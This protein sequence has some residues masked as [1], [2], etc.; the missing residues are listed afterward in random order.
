MLREK[1]ADMYR[2][3][4]IISL[5]GF[6]EKFVFQGVH[7]DFDYDLKGDWTEP[8]NERVSKFV[9]I[10]KKLDR[11][12]LTDGFRGCIV[13][14]LRFKVGDAVEAKVQKGWTPGVVLKTWER[15]GMQVQP[16]RIKLE[17]GVEVYGPFDNDKY[18]R[19]PELQ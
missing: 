18:V 13:P 5:K 16:Y 14:E 1:N 15:K 19:R 10:G 8:E 12:M 17:T 2:Y 11:Q 9:F 4:G 6:E 7:D 3:K